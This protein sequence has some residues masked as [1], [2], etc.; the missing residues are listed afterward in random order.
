MG[1]DSD[2]IRRTLSC[3][4]LNEVHCVSCNAGL[5]LSIVEDDFEDRVT[6]S[7]FASFVEFVGE[8]R[9]QTS[10]TFFDFYDIFDSNPTLSVI[11]FRVNSPVFAV[12]AF[13]DDI[14]RIQL[15]AIG[16]CGA[17][18]EIGDV[19]IPAWLDRSQGLSDVIR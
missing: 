12:R 14:D 9:G 18:W 2:D 6:H 3:R 16:Q 8:S 11:V 19:S 15:S 7:R 13:R 10:W 1:E 5:L 4:I 17:A